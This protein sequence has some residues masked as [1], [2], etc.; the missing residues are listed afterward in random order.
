MNYDLNKIRSF[1]EYTLR[2]LAII[3]IHIRARQ[4]ND[5]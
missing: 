5:N 3:I 2:P 4:G 1:D